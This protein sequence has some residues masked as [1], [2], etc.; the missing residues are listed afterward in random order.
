MTSTRFTPCAAACAALILCAAPLHAADVSVYG[1]VDSGVVY[2]NFSGDSTKDDAFSMESGLNTASRW[3]IR[4]S[5]RLTDDVSVSFRLE[6]RFASDTGAIKGGRLFEGSAFLEVSSRTWGELAAGRIAGVNSGSGPWDVQILMDAFGGGTFGTALA[7][8]KSSRM[9]NMI[10]YR[11]PRAAGLQ[12]TVQHSLQTDSAAKGDESTSDVDR[13]WAAGLTWKAGERLNLVAV[14]EGTTWGRKDAKA[15]DTSRKVFTVGGNL[16]IDDV[17]LYAQAQYFNGVDKLDGFATS[18]SAAPSSE[19]RNIKGCG[20]YAGVQV[21][22]GPSSLQSMAYWRDYDVKAAADGRTHDGSSLGV[23]AKYVYRPS[24]TIDMYAGGGWSQWDR[25]S[26]G[27]IL[28]DR[29][30]N[31]FSGVTKY[32]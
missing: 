27:R 31:L 18:S 11:S 24:K 8:V 3:G 22:F 2:Q 4:G 6:N 19:T 10:T 30:F 15:P 21:W 7:P 26:G 17:A 9:D 23:A 25:L 28:T 29:S 14:Y 1:R 16:R 13:F 12:A 20:L 5:E 32:F